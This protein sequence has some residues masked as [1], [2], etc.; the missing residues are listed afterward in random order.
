M[1]TTIEE[2]IE[3]VRDLRLAMPPG[4][5]DADA[6]ALRLILAEVERLKGERDE[7][8]R[9]RDHYALSL[10]GCEGHLTAA[11][12]RAKQ[13]EEASRWANKELMRRAA[14]IEGKK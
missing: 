8:I 6:E 1:S 9:Q 12:A 2:A 3:R 13:M 7:L 5:A 11:E 14:L 4:D 10:R